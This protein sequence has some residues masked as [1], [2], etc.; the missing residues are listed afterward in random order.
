MSVAVALP[1]GTILLLSEVASKVMFAG[2]DSF[3][4]VV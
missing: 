2:T 3:G 4:G 1:I